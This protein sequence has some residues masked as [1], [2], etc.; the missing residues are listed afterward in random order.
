MITLSPRQRKDLPKVSASQGSKVPQKYQIPPPQCLESSPSDSWRS[1]PQTHPEV[2]LCLSSGESYKILLFF[3][4]NHSYL[5]SSILQKVLGRRDFPDGSAIKNPPAMQ[6]TQEMQFLSLG[7][8]DPLEEE[9]A[10]HSSILAWRIPQTEEPGGLQSIGS[11]RVG[12]Y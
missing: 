9:M 1:A 6:E 11:Q 10:T 5:P 3:Y 4:S 2:Y 7:G 12:H 8:E